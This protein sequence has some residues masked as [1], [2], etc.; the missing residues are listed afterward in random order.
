MPF[1]FRKEC[2]L[3]SG[4]L[5]HVATRLELP[6]L[7][8]SAEDFDAQLRAQFG[9]S[10]AQKVIDATGNQ[11]AMNNTVNL[12]RHGGTVVFVGLFKG[13]LQFSDPEF[14]K[15]ETTM[16]GSRNA[17]PED[18]AKVGRLMAE[19]KITADMMLTHRY[20][21][22]TLAETYERDVIN[23]RELIKGVITF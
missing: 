17:T 14:H 9:G 10:L 18:F 2:P 6:L 16:M 19:G 21:F 1:Y 15:K 5:K 3:N 23:N 12:I 11:H 13:E 8:P 20:P 4:Y 22:A 7:D